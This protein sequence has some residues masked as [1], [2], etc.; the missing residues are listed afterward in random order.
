MMH[1]SICIHVHVCMCVYL[2]MYIYGFTY[3]FTCIFMYVHV[4]LVE[5]RSTH[6]D[7]YASWVTRD[8]RCGFTQRSFYVFLRRIL[9]KQDVEDKRN[10][11]AG[12]PKEVTTSARLLQGL[13]G[14][15]NSVDPS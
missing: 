11:Q 13:S 10:K 9:V 2:Y 8:P 1:V 3:M 4:Y 14:S 6:D 7:Q 5:S 15:F 12:R